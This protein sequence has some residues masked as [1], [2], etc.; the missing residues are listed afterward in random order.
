MHTSSRENIVSK[1]STFSSGIS[2]QFILDTLFCCVFEKN[3]DNNLKRKLNH[4]KQVERRTK[5]LNEN[6][7]ENY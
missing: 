4:A 3:Y 2:I 6:S 5:L 7:L 1:I